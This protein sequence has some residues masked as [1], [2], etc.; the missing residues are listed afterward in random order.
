[1][2]WQDVVRIDVAIS[3]RQFHK[4]ETI[5]ASTKHAKATVVYTCW[6]L[7]ELVPSMMSPNLTIF[8]GL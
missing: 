1:M 6:D 7:Y 4:N 3:K 2:C 8:T 5:L